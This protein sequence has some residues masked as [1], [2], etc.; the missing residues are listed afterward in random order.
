MQVWEAPMSIFTYHPEDPDTNPM[1]LQKR[2]YQG[3][4]G[5]VYPLPFTDRIAT[6]GQYKEWK[7]IHIENRFLRLM[8]LPEIGG[9]IHVGLDKTNGYDF[10]YRQNVIKP[11]LVGLAGPWISGGV[12]F[13]W[14][15]HHRPGTFLPVE[16][17][18]EQHADGSVTV[19]CGDYDRGTGLKGMHGVCLHP[20]RALVELKVRLYNGTGQV[21][22]FLWWANVAARV[23][24]QYQSFFP[25]DVRHV[26]DHAKRAISTFPYA[27]GEYYGIDYGRR[28]REGVSPDE[29][30]RL[31]TPEGYPANDLS[32]YANI[33]VPTSYMVLHTAEDFFGG[34]DHRAR[35]GFVHVANHHIA[36]GKKQW[37]WGNH[38]FGYA[39]DRCLTEADGPYIEL[40][41]GVYTDNQPDFSF[42]GPGETK[43]FSQYWYPLRE[44]GIPCAANLEGAI[45][46]RM[47]EGIVRTSL[48]VTRA[49]PRATVI[50]SSGEREIARWNGDLHVAVP[51]AL[52]VPLPAGCDEALLEVRLQ[53][54]A[55][56]TLLMTPGP[57]KTAVS[58]PISEPTLAKEPAAPEE[59]A[60]V[61]LL[62][63][64]GL[65]LEQYRH[66]TRSA[67]PYWREGLRRDPGDM[68]CNHA[69][70]KLHLRRCEYGLAERHLLAA[71]ERAT[72]LNPNPYDG[73]VFYTLGLVL[74]RLN[75]SDEAYAAFYKSTWNASWQSAGYFALAEMDAARGDLQ[76][77][78]FHVR[79]ALKN[80]SE[81]LN[82]RNLCVSLLRRLRQMDEAAELLAETRALDPLDLWSR[83][84]QGASLNASGHALLS[85]ALQMQR[86]GFYED[87]GDLLQ[88]ALPVS[89]DG[90]SPLI[91][92]ALARCLQMAGES[93]GDSALDAAASASQKHCFPSG[94]DHYDLLT[95]AVSGRPQA[96]SFHLYLGNL[97]FH[98][99]RAA[100]AIQAWEQAVS[101][102]SGIAQAWRNLGI[103]FFNQKGDASAAQH[104]FRR[105]VAAAPGDARLLYE[106]DQLHKRVGVDPARRLKMLLDSGLVQQ[107]DDLSVEVATLYNHLD[108][109]SEALDV[110]LSRQFQPWEG[111]EGLVLAQY[112][113]ALLKLAQRDLS[114]R[115]ALR[116]I[117]HLLRVQASPENLGEAKHL[118]AN[119]SNVHYWLG[120][121]YAAAGDLPE[122]RLS[123]GR[124]ATFS[125]DFQGM[126]LHA[127]SEMTYW[128]GCSLQSLGREEEAATLF[129]KLLQYSLDLEERPAKIDYFATSLPSLLLFEDD[130]QRRNRLRARL[131]RAA[132]LQGMGHHPQARALAEEVLIADPTSAF[133]ADL[134]QHA[135][136]LG[137]ISVPQ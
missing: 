66:A 102:D 76:Q 114:S 99:R 1:F 100:E 124:S 103:A 23:H 119:D 95:M 67:E 110:L 65:H 87:A 63:L 93:A 132:A 129:T 48:C 56:V 116:A 112:T 109:P 29:A 64:T 108:Q 90:S 3:S 106:Q 107:R 74:Q 86:A 38:N 42:L 133:A 53:S 32:R 22:T 40:M 113:A 60:S 37:T 68:R 55:G 104:A 81:D 19:W 97:L 18:I 39:W 80:N 43:A 27:D 4:S 20:D 89:T 125:G 51:F 120:V 78:L 21:Q 5:E 54:A 41:A 134:L 101:A 9:R 121:A 30:P 98:H 50:I 12:E 61:D 73:E 36:P 44:T 91:H 75:R 8:I 79:L 115:D 59:I 118:L 31:F 26:A 96:A 28:A 34:Y 136:E 117:A 45:G 71:K 11:A 128:S 58:S 17:E 25:S 88:R 85:L 131:L 49:V 16:T 14:P 72:S 122:S 69:L 46:M 70:G 10:F 83:Y 15:Q 6:L 111:G 77:G 13:N 130:L 94:C 57:H 35:A 33:P 2:V 52:E 123:F 47:E 127:F 92:L 84:L 105:A 7:A 126:S 137:H 62:F 135:G 24:E 82:A